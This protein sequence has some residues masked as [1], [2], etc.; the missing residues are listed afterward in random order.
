MNTSQLKS[1]LS[2]NCCTKSSFGGVYPSDL[3]PKVVQDY[4][5]S[6]VANV[7]PKTK[8]GSHWVAFYFTTEE[9]GEFFDF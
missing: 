2:K 7:D 8:P 1:I 6:F 4:P 9:K 5:Q 3:L